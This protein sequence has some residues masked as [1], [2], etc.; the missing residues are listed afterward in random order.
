MFHFLL[1]EA[2][3][4]RPVGSRPI[5][6]EQRRLPAPGTWLSDPAESGARFRAWLRDMRATFPPGSRNAH[7]FGSRS[8]GNEND[9]W[10]NASQLSWLVGPDGRTILVDDVIKLE[11]WNTATHHPTNYS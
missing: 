11:V 5:H 4:N 9:A 7:F 8:H 1:Q 2:S 3:C 6:C 10:F